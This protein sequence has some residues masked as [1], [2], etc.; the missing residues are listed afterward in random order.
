M[1]GV[2]GPLEEE[3]EVG[4]SPTGSSVG[5]L[6]QAHT[7]VRA[8]CC[9]REG[10]GGAVALGLVL[11]KRLGTVVE[12]APRVG[13][14]CRRDGGGSDAMRRRTVL[15]PG[16][17]FSHSVLPFGA[18]VI[19]NDSNVEVGSEVGVP[20]PQLPLAALALPLRVPARLVEDSQRS[21]AG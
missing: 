20:P 5:A 12:E 2:E 3:M 9:H 11:P 7:K 15:L 14:L 4:V 10:V 16:R 18:T 17:G 1:G 21:P 13:S 19:A 6:K 8:R